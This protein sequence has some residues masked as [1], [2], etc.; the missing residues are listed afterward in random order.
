MAFWN[1]ADKAMARHIFA[2]FR[3]QLN[4]GNAHRKENAFQIIRKF[5]VYADI[6]QDFKNYQDFLSRKN[7]MMKDESLH[8]KL[9]HSHSKM[10]LLITFIDINGD[11]NSLNYIRRSKGFRE[12]YRE[13][14]GYKELENSKTKVSD[15]KSIQLRKDLTNYDF[16]KKL[17]K[18]EELLS[19]SKESQKDLENQIQI[20]RNDN[21]VLRKKL[22][23]ITKLD[24]SNNELQS[25]VESSTQTTA[26]FL[27]INDQ[28][29]SLN[30]LERENADEKNIETL[31]ENIETLMIVPESRN[32]LE[33]DYAKLQGK[34]EAFEKF[35]ETFKCDLR[36]VTDSRNEM[37][38][39]N[40]RLEVKLEEAQKL[41][42]TLRLDVH[43]L[44]QNNVKLREKVEMV[45]KLNGT[46]ES[47]LI[48]LTRKRRQHKSANKH[49]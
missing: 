46:L 1:D 37:E 9:E 48:L 43:D 15:D 21:N 7:D 8:Q 47:D 44:K 39:G 36:Q 5:S 25:K 10:G 38:R 27:D 6:L 31:E 2:R 13:L 11:L 34:L 19:A 28:N 41:N 4:H 24:Q 14:L 23:N 49:F 29:E 12:I 3:D 45:E 18:S 16:Q 26:K 20:L 33:I 40:V 42:E 35:I 22:E 32:K 30:A 17:L